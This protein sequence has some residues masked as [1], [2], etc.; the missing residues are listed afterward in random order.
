VYFDARSDPRK[1]SIRGN[2]HFRYESDT[3]AID[4]KVDAS[5]NKSRRYL[6]ILPLEEVNPSDNDLPFHAPFISP[7]SKSED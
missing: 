6:K 4:T 1:S 5:D 7:Q 2:N 3:N